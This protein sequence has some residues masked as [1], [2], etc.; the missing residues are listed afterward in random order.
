MTHLT[1]ETMTPSKGMASNA[2]KETQGEK[3]TEKSEENE[4]APSSV[5]SI[6]AAVPSPFAG[7]Y[8]GGPNGSLAGVPPIMPATTPLLA[9]P[10]T[11]GF[12]V[13]SSCAASRSGQPMFVT[14]PFF[15][16]NG[17]S[18]PRTQEIIPDGQRD[19]DA[20]PTHPM[21]KGGG[22]RRLSR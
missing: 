12:A 10:T 16:G 21:S 19:P 6:R 5:P 9:P 8:P 4:G 13:P 1:K 15:P 22:R 3:E 18:G 11:T 20:D 7:V 2:K 14:S 17:G